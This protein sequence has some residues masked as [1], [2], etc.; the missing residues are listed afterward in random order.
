MTLKLDNYKHTNTS[1]LATICVQGPDHVPDGQGVCFFR[2]EE[3]E[4][5]CCVRSADAFA[6]LRATLMSAV[7]VRKCAFS[8]ACH[9]C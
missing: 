7:I 8:C 1:I 5:L 4:A 6:S 3:E 9:H 2:A